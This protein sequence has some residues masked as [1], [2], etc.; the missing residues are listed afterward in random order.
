MNLF[1]FLFLTKNGRVKFPT[2]IFKMKRYRYRKVTPEMVEKMEKL[3]AGGMTY[4]DI[5]KEFGLSYSVTYYN[6]SERERLRK[7]KEAT[8]FNSRM[9]RK[10]R[11]ERTKKYQPYTSQYIKERYNNDEE[12]RL[13][14]L[15]S[16]KRSQKKILRERKEKGLCTRCGGVRKDKKRAYCGKC[17]ER[18]RNEIKRRRESERQDKDNL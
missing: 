17:R 6:L 5:G 2:F 1:Y 7:K 11:K 9:T 4:K 13:R 18:K 15:E 14:F 16:V 12:F 8:E 3:R 10:Q